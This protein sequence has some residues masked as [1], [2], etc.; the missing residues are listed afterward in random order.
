MNSTQR[1]LSALFVVSSMLGCAKPKVDKPAQISLVPKVK[2]EQPELRDIQRNIAQPGAIEAYEQTS[3]YSKIP[4]F[5]QKWHVDVGD[6]VKK[7]DLL[8]EL[9][10]PELADEHTQKVAQVEQSKAVVHQSEKLV[11]VAESNVQA[12]Q[13]AVAEAKANIDRYLADVDRW[14][15][16]LNRLTGLAKDGV[17]NPEILAETQN[18]L[19]SSEAALESARAAVKSKDSQRLAAEAQVGKAK[20]DL[21][22][23]RA[24]IKVAVAEEQ[25]LA[26]MF[27]YTKINA[28]YD[29]VITSRNVSTGDFVRAGAGNASEGSSAE[30]SGGSSMPMLVVTRTDPMVFVIGVPEV[31][32]P[33]VN[34]GTKASLRLQALAGR[35]FDVAVS[36]IAPTLNKQSRTLMAEVDLPNPKGELLPGMYAYG[37]IELNRSKVR[38][39]PNSA[40][41]QIGNR[42]CCYLVDNGKALRTQIQTGVTDGNWTEVV[43][44]ESYPTNAQSGTWQ[45][46]DG[47]EKVI[48][49]DL[50]EISD[51]EQVALDNIQVQQ[52]KSINLPAGHTVAATTR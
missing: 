20:A 16:E 12:A 1:F 38:A 41:V 50:S 13:D 52:P 48:V 36:R 35:E 31:D 15:G 24:Q 11:T 28:P 30:G 2:V 43:K 17:V 51:G 14:Q 4:G 42:M 34:V 33:Y 22:A 39:I 27:Q 40:T 18:Q 46:F 49:G 32:A 26:A 7:G 47:S 29:G 37:S 9:V 25:R 23:S 5:V 10:V 44:K 6:R 45:E 8:I 3:I 19:K 21:N